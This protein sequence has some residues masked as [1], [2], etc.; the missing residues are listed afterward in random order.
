MATTFRLVASPEE[1]QIL[2]DWFAKLP[3]PPHIHPRSDGAALFFRQFGPLI[4]T[5]TNQVDVKQSPVVL[6]VLPQVRHEVLWTA[7][8]VQFLAERMRSSFPGLQ[9]VLTSFRQWVRT[10]PVVFRQPRLPETSGGPWDYYLEGGIRNVSDEVFAL[11]AG[12]AA[13]E[14]GQYF[15]WQGD[16]EGRLD[17]VLRMLRLRGVTIAEPDA[18]GNSRHA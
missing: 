17:T 10:F 1:G 8:E 15:I 2:L 13:L 4:M 18:A 5:A 16:S 7:G 14:R 12:M 11:P 6:L 9:K 3:E